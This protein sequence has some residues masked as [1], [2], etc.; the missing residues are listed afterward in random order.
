MH[1]SAGGPPGQADA[2]WNEMDE[3]K[4]PYGQFLHV[5]VD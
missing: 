2:K 5:L 1:Y 3:F 4:D